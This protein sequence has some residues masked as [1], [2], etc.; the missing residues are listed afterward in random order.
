[1]FPLTSALDVPLVVLGVVADRGSFRALRSPR[2]RDGSSRRDRGVGVTNCAADSTQLI[3]MMEA[4][5]DSVD[6][7]PQQVLADAGYRSEANFD[8]RV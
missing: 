7:Q 3:P 5:Q 8:E 2:N 1:V 4:T 6:E